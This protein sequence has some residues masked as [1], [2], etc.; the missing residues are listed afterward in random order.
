M[1]LYRRRHLDQQFLRT[2][3][4]IFTTLGIM[5]PKSYAQKPWRLAFLWVMK[6]KYLEEGYNHMFCKNL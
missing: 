3:L 2:G 5:L 1:K 4:E 6:N